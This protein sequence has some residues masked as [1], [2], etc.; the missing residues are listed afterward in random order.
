MTEVFVSAH[1]KA[2]RTY[3]RRWPLLRLDR[4]YA[5]NAHSQHALV[6]PRGR[7]R[8]FPTTRHSLPSS[9]Y[10]LAHGGRLRVGARQPVELLENGE[11]YFPAVL[12]AIARA[13][14]EVLIETFILFEDKVAR[15]CS[16]R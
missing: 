13:R 16:A 9:R 4:I 15:R 2:A 1:G 3:P 5:R 11:G 6:L 8:I 7:G 14:H 12:D 10:E